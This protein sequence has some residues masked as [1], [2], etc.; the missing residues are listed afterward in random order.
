MGTV[1]NTL[2]W[3]VETWALTTDHI[4]SLRSCFNKCVRS[5]SRVTWMDQREHHIHDA[6]LRERLGLNALEGIV[7]M[8][9]LRYL[10]RVACMQGHRLSRQTVCAQST[11]KGANCQRSR[12]ATTQAAWRTTLI[13]AGLASDTVEAKVWMRSIRMKV[14]SDIIDSK[15]GLFPGTYAK[16]RKQL[17]EARAFQNK[18]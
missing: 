7:R 15:L 1:V 16:G 6:H 17:R 10:E 5:M 3:G 11:K 18:I 12:E 8:R 14:A 9:Q 4:T 13:K 2:L